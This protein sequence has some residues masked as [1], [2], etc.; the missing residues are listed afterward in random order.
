MSARADELRLQI[1]E[2][3]KEY[4]AEAFPE[5]E[6]V[7]GNSPVPYAGRVFDEREIQ[8]LVQLI[9]VHAPGSPSPTC[10]TGVPLFKR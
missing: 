1:A 2:L 6:F 3:V 10:G 8:H 4:H 7:P 5:R 9:A